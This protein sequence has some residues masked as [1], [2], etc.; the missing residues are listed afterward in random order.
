MMPPMSSGAM[1][2]EMASVSLP[3]TPGYVLG[4]PI[5]H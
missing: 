3:S 2:M 4:E 1:E 5:I